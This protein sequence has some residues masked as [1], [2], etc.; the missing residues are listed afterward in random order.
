MKTRPDSPSPWLTPFPRQFVDKGLNVS[1]WTDL[2]PYFQMLEDHPLDTVDEL[3]AWLL[4]WSELKE[5]VDEFCT[6]R[7]IEMT[8]HTDDDKKSQDYLYCVREVEPEA[9]A[10][11]DRLNRKYLASSALDDLDKGK[12]GQ[13]TRMIKEGVELFDEKNIPLQVE[14]SELSQEYQKIMG[15]MTVHFEGEEKT[16]PQMS[17]YLLGVD[18]KKRKSAYVAIVERRKKEEES[19]ENIFDNML[20]LRARWADN[21]GLPDYREYCFRSK[22]RDYTPDDC[23]EFHNAIE[24]AAV[25]LARELAEKRKMEL[26]LEKLAPW[27][28]SCDAKGLGPLK[29]FEKPDDL[30]TGVHNIFSSVDSR[31]GDMFG[32]IRFSMDLESRKGKAP[33]GYQATLAEARIPFI[34]TNAV[35]THD[36][37][38]TL[39]HEG[40]HAFHTLKCRDLPLVWYHHASM[41]F[42]EVASMSMELVGGERLEPFYEKEEERKRAMRQ[43]MEWIVNLFLWVAQV[44]AFQ[45]WIYTNPGHTGK[46]RVNAWVELSGRFNAGVDWSLAPAGSLEYSWHRQLHIFELPFYYIEYAIA[47]LGAL[48]IYRKYKEDKSKAIEDYLNALS[49]G[50]SRIPKDLFS[51]ANI[52]FDFSEELL[53]GLMDFVKHE[54]SELS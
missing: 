16:L 23:Y 7:Y 19:L 46:E 25:P 33:G 22:L 3:E 6:K 32:A 4:K 54:I 31:L 1:K 24:K 37:V 18:R 10:W 53:R 5:V 2:E 9:T 45:H 50:G 47:Q 38:N 30:F 34:F 39:L 43:R 29:P 13:L 42:A 26:G 52:R 40:G 44:D 11:E 27:D 48:Q 17:A 49:L 35:G 36:D 41:E 15:A 8:C 51:A 14:L 12:Y 20:G 28:T 21:L